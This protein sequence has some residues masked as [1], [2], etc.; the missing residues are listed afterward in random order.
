MNKEAVYYRKTD[1]KKF[2]DFKDGDC[3]CEVCNGWGYFYDCEDNRVSSCYHCQGEGKLDWVS[4]ITGV[5]G[6]SGTPGFAGSAGMNGTSAFG[7]SGSSGLGNSFIGKNP[8]PSSQPP[9]PL[10]GPGFPPPPRK[11][12]IPPR[13]VVKKIPWTERIMN[14]VADK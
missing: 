10:K 14:A 4:N 5:A 11:R 7:S 6:M 13:K 8:P 2:K 1:I 12:I 3:I 9:S